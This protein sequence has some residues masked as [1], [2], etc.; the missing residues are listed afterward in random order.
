MTEQRDWLDGPKLVSWLKHNA[1]LTSPKA[2][3]GKREYLIRRWRDGGKASVWLV[4][5]V[6]V[7]LGVCMGE[8]PDEVWTSPPSRGTPIA[9]EFVVEIRRRLAV[10]ESVISISR[11]LG[12]DPKT[13]RRYRDLRLLEG[14][15]A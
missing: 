15:Q 14:A 1:G 4:D 7:E 2:Q 12:V 11:A 3:L 6:L 8:L 9:Q 5:S 10:A 13:V